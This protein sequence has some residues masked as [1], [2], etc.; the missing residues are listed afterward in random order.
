MRA[1][2]EAI[3]ADVEMPIASRCNAGSQQTREQN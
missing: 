3:D 2:R 1:D